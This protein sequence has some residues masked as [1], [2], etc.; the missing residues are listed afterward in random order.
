MNCSALFIQAGWQTLQKDFP[1]LNKAQIHKVLSEYQLGND[2]VRPKGWL[3]PPE[4]MDDAVRTS[5]VPESFNNHPPLH[6][7]SEG[8]CL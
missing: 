6:I 2:A 4:E 8:Q 5:D 3:P 1:S 7:P